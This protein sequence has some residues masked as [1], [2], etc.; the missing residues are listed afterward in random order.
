MADRADFFWDFA[1]AL[2][3]GAWRRLLDIAENGAHDVGDLATAAAVI[4]SFHI[5]TRFHGSTFTMA[6]GILHS[7]PKIYFGAENGLFERYFNRCF[8]VLPP[9]ASAA[10]ALAAAE[11][12]AEYIAQPQVAEIKAKILGAGAKAGKRIAIAGG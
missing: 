7:Q 12:T 9:V 5:I 3:F 11:K 6:A 2:T 4:A 10:A 1:A 8:N